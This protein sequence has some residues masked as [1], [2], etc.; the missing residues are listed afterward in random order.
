[1]DGRW[2]RI[3][4]RQL[5]SMQTGRLCNRPTLETNDGARHGEVVQFAIGIGFI[6]PQGGGKDIFVHI[7]AVEK[8]GLAGLKPTRLVSARVLATG[9]SQF[10]RKCEVRANS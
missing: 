8:A 2:E 10:M 6:Q 4:S 7:S 1:M 9:A 5:V 3:A